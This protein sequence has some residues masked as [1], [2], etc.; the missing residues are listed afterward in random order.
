VDD[1][2]VYCLRPFGSGVIHFDQETYSIPGPVMV[3]LKDGH[4]N[5]NITERDRT[6]ISVTSD[7]EPVGITVELE[8]TAENTAVFSGTFL[9]TLSEKPE[10]GHLYVQY[11]DVIAAHYFDAE[12]PSEPTGVELTTSATVWSPPAEPIV[13][14]ISQD[15]SSEPE[16]VTLSWPYDENRAYR[17]YYTDDLVGE[18]PVWQRASGLPAVQGGAL[19]T[20]AEPVSPL[21]RRRFYRIEAW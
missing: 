9:L 4:L 17:L 2:S 3:T 6:T 21:S 19:M 8:E 20:F 12:R 18:S 14:V 5:L 15:A 7:S 1:V 16:V 13:P 10:S 11:G